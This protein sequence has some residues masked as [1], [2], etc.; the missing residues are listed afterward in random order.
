MGRVFGSEKPSSK[1]Q[2]TQ[3][4]GSANEISVN[5]EN[6]SS[7]ALIDTGSMVS[8]M[9]DS[10]CSKLQLRVRSLEDLM[11]LEGAGGHALCYSGYVEVELQVLPGWKLDALFLVV[12][13]TNYNNRVPLLIGTN[14]LSHIR[15][16][17]AKTSQ[18]RLPT[19]LQLGLDCLAQVQRID[20]LEVRSTKSVTIPAQGSLTIP[21]LSHAGTNCMR[22]SVVMEYH[23]TASLPQG[24]ILLPTFLTINTG[25]T[26]RVPVQVQNVSCRDITIPARS[27]LCE[28][29]PG[30]TVL[31]P[32]ETDQSSENNTTLLSQF[33]WDAI[34]A[35]LNENQVNQVE[36]LITKWSDAFAQH[37]MDLGQTSIV[38][39]QIKLMD[40]VPFKERA[41]RIPPSMFE[42]VRLHIQEMLDLG[43]IRPSHSPYASPVVLVRKKNG[44]LRFCIDLRKLNNKTIKDAYALPRIEE[45]LDVLRGSKWFSALDL[46]S[47]YWQIEMAEEDKK[48]TAF[49]VGPLGFYECNRM[50]FGLTNAPASFQRCAEECLGGLNL[51]QCLVYLDDI[52]IFSE[53]YDEHMVRLEA[54]FQRLQDAGLKISPTKCQLFQRRIKYLGH[55]V[56]EEGIAADPSKVE[57]IQNW[58]VPNTVE[59]VR[60]FLG[61]VGFLRKFMKDFG[62]VARPLHNLLK[63]RDSGKSTKKKQKSRKQYYPFEWDKDKQSAFDQLKKL[64]CSAP[65]LAFANYSKPFILHTDASGDGLGAVL[66]QE[67]DGSE[68]PLA[69]ASR[70]LNKAERNYPAHK[71]E[72]LALK[73]AVTDKFHD[74]LY[75][76][77][78]LARTDNNPLT[79]VLSSA[80][81]DATGHRWV[82]ELANYHFR[83]EYRAGKLNKDAD[84]L[85]RIIWPDDHLDITR[86][87]VVAILQNAHTEGGLAEAYCLA[88]HM[89]VPASGLSLHAFDLKQWAEH[90]RKDPELRI[91]I[92][93]LNDLEHPV[94]KEMTPEVKTLLRQKGKLCL[95][96]GVLYRKRI[97][98]GEDKFQLVLP[99]KYRLEALKGCHDHL[100]H[101]GRERTLEVIQERFYWPG[102]ST[103]VREYV[104]ACDRCT[105]RKS[106]IQRAPLT[107]ISTSYPMELVSMDYLSLETSKGG[108][109]NVLV[110]VDHFTRFAQ[111]YPTR[112][113]TAHTTAK[114]LYE[115]FFTHY[116]FPARLHSDQ[117]RNFVSST[118]RHLCEITGVMKSRTSPYHP[119]G[120]GMCERFNSTL[121]SML[122]TLQPDQKSDWKAYVSALTHAYNCTRHESTGFSPFFLMFGHHPRLPVDI[123]LGVEESSDGPSYEQFVKK[124]QE[125]LRYAYS[126][127]S[128][129]AAEAQKAQRTRYDLRTRGNAVLPGDRVLV[130]NVGLKGRHKIADRWKQDT[131]VIL[132][133]PNK[134]IPVF[135]VQREDGRGP[136]KVLHRN[137]LLPI[138]SIPT[139]AE[140]QCKPPPLAKELPITD[141][142]PVIH[143]DIDTPIIPTLYSSED[144]SEGSA[145][146][147]AEPAVPEVK[148]RPVP[149]PRRLRSAA[150]AI[151]RVLSNDPISDP[152]NESEE[153]NRLLGV[154][155]D[156]SSSE[157]DPG[158]PIPAL[159]RSSRTRRRPSQ[160]GQ[161]AVNLEQRALML[162]NLVPHL[163]QVLLDQ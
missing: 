82:S 102:V 132:C 66:Y 154:Q 60:R 59:E 117:G 147:S 156:S 118:I 134:E 104:S 121:L 31:Q 25:K 79:Y 53:T 84:S 113:Q 137:M 19:A 143:P 3:L 8:T 45:T 119:M 115:N 38:K 108:I 34:N 127:A 36:Q 129:K 149:A 76:H 97:L 116:G 99:A 163:V 22:L 92:A 106:A 46:K 69:Y 109:E 56:S 33:N 10:L 50:C 40:D 123:L 94:A 157:S 30:K 14:I 16:E 24:L 142:L 141:H 131:Y 91:I 41:R 87:A 81:L 37:D 125:R 78:F 65:V 63:E 61:F 29:H 152:D 55:I 27:I 86:D 114:V 35:T 80:K 101:L 153:G 98:Q 146:D 68:R 57:A 103:T 71:L 72:F 73:W 2:K 133:Q 13:E 100:G 112:N 120:N 111:A 110:I 44:S 105:R 17:L 9:S 11:K 130:R 18:G 122:G 85:S 70:S 162:Q 148:V 96:S 49:T 150:R 95:R 138:T 21:G 140:V 151:P 139:A 145:S 32:S 47:G 1:R 26:L 58:P 5:V 124:L 135:E 144:H 62:K 64:C 93:V 28:L 74:Y 75:G 54:V 7:L 12:P 161:T 48:K 67:Q 4:I 158:P 126:L 42:E 160:F 88:Q 39:H 20:S 159:R 107:S 52:I 155:T 136:T 15:D 51:S 77:E 23:S 83:I 89:P 90:Q 128:A 43:V 6:D